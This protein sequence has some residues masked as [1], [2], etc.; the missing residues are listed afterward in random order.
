MKI[1]VLELGNAHEKKE[2]VFLYNQSHSKLELIL[3]YSLEE[4]VSLAKKA[5]ETK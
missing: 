1:P 5:K 2:S 3:K 4:L